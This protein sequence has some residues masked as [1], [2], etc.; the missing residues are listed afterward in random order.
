MEFP[1]PKLDKAD[2]EQSV[3]AVKADNLKSVQGVVPGRV[4]TVKLE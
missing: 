1:T 3:C 2:A 4:F